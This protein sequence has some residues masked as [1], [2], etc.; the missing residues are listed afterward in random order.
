MQNTPK[1]FLKTLSIIHAALVIGPLLIAA[2]F[3]MN[4]ALVTNGTQNDIFIYVFPILALAG[5][6]AS[7]FMF[8]LLV[9]NVKNQERLRAKL[10]G[11][12]TASVI[13]FALLEGPAILNIAWFG[14][15]GNLLYLTIGGVLILFLFM[16]RPKA[17]K[18]ENELELN[19]EH[20]RQFR[21]LD[22]PV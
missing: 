13:K 10:A 22:E 12:Q 8:N 19:S 18:I 16:Q 3:Y 5:I 20:K 2:F 7:K 9:K 4:T 11:Y 14:F 21:K 6:F 15:S 1:Q 17:E